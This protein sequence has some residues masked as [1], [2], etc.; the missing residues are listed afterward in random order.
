MNWILVL[1]SEI[2]MAVIF[3]LIGYRF[4]ERDGT[5]VA[6]AEF[7]KIV[8][9]MREDERKLEEEYRDLDRRI[10]GIRSVNFGKEKADGE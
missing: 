2:L 3:W 10:E 9:E 7:D 8:E 6:R 5:R 4:G 1:V